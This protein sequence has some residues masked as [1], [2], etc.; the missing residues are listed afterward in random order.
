MCAKNDEGDLGF[1]M[2]G[3]GPNFVVI[4]GSELMISGYFGQQ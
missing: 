1:E 3:L 2:T 4:L